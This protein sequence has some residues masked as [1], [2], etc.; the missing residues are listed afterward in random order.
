M[1]PISIPGLWEIFRVFGPFG[2]VTIIWYLDMKALRK[3]LDSYKDDMAE[4]RRMYEDNIKLVKG[5]ESLSGD[6]KDLIVLNT[7]CLTRLSDEIRQNQYCPM[8]RVQKE[9]IAVRL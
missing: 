4:I 1:D 6:L 5:Y 7:Q 3:V 9:K 8:V 2:L